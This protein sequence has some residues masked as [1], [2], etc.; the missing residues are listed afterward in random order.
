MGHWVLPH[1]LP[2]L[3]ELLLK[4]RKCLMSE[5]GT[6]PETC[7]GGWGLKERWYLWTWGGW[8]PAGLKRRE[9]V[10]TKRPGQGPKSPAGQDIPRPP[11]VGGLRQVLQDL[12]A[13]VAP[14][15]TWMYRNMG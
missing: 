1:R 12:K 3:L 8:A 15:D 6:G 2:H 7:P 5:L 4:L 11:H 9:A 14:A 10:S 13:H